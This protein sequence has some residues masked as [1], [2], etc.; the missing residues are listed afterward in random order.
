MVERY[1][2]QEILD[3]LIVEIQKI[4]KETYIDEI[5]YSRKILDLEELYTD[6]IIKLF[7]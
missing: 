6:K 1:D 7:Q 2:V 4:H 5:E 3:E